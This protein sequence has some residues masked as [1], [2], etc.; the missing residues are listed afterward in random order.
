MEKNIKNAYLI[1][2]AVHSDHCPVALE[3]MSL[4]IRQFLKPR[5]YKHKCHR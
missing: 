3:L 2:E 4:V 1:P 5:Q